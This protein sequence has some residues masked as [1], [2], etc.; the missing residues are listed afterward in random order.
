MSCHLPDDLTG[1]DIGIDLKPGLNREQLIARLQR[2]FDAQPRKQ[3]SHVLPALL[4]G[5]LAE[6]FPTLCGV[7]GGKV[8]AQISGA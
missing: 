1:L 6:L 4:P 7:D 8:C 2:E 3:L 5:S